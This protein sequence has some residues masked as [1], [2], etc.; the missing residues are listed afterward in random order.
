MIY[1][2][3]TENIGRKDGPAVR[4]KDRGSQVGGLREDRL[5]RL[6]TY[7]VADIGIPCPT[8]A[9]AAPEGARPQGSGPMSGVWCSRP[10]GRIDQMGKDAA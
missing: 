1:T 8:W 5:H 4:G 3:R 7:G 9:G 2:E 10:S 6:R